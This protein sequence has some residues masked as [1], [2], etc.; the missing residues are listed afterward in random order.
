VLAR[1][2]FLTSMDRLIGITDTALPDFV[3]L[4]DDAPNPE[5][6]QAFAAIVEEFTSARKAFTEAE[7]TVNAVDPLTV[8]AYEAGIGRFSDGVRNVALASTLMGNVELPE[9]YTA[10]SPAAAQCND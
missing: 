10:A 9:E 8:E 6:R 3:V 4:R 2:E 1:R 5:V 7:A